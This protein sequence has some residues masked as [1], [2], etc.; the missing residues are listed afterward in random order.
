MSLIEEAL[1]KQKEEVEQFGKTPP[2][3]PPLLE[4]SSPVPEPTEAVMSARPWGLLAGL[5]L[6]GILL[7]LLILWL[8]FY[9]MHLWRTSPGIPAPGLKSVAALATN[10]TVAVTTS[11]VETASIPTNSPSATGPS[12]SVQSTQSVI[13]VT[14]PP[15]PTNQPPPLIV[16]VATTEKT[17]LPAIWPRLLI[18]GVIG[19][20][21]TGHSAVIINGRL[22]SLGESIDSVKVMAIDKQRVKLV[23]EGEERVLSA[24]S[25]TE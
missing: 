19:G 6:G 12:V 15:S 25:T 4:T 11:R 9:G 16:P 21:K 17:P 24:G 18:S 7:I 20:G 2:V 22:L 5:F 14:T 10:S 3:P 8:L 1:R 13:T 23:Y